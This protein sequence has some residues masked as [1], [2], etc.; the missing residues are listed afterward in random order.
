MSFNPKAVK[1]GE[2]KQTDT[3]ETT[4]IDTDK[5]VA[6][7]KA[8]L[9]AMRE[10][11]RSISRGVQLNQRH[12]EQMDKELEEMAHE[13]ALTVAQMAKQVDIVD[14]K[15]V[16]SYEAQAEA[17]SLPDEPNV[18]QTPTPKAKATKPTKK[19][20]SKKKNDHDLSF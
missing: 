3:K 2:A 12:D 15:T 5:A 11:Q 19:Q 14:D 17:P 6:D 7:A 13:H 8:K 10:R 1:Y 4:T 18:K 16:G 20:K 9:D